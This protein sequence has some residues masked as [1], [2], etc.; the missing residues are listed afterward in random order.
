MQLKPGSPFS[1]HT[2][3]S[4]SHQELFLFSLENEWEF[5]EIHG[6]GGD[7]LSLFRSDWYL[8]QKAQI[9]NN[10]FF[11]KTN[12]FCKEVVVFSLRNPH[13]SASCSRK[14]FNNL[15]CVLGTGYFM[16]TE[17]RL[18]WMLCSHY[19]QKENQLKKQNWKVKTSDDLKHQ[20]E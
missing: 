10:F 9:L 1:M 19:Q 11:L 14:Y 16:L 7:F 5:F 4:W 15:H 13:S 8:L 20:K 18:L 12:L 17:N 2:T 6:L 3:Y